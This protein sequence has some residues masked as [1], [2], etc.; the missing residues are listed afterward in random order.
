MEPT[1]VTPEIVDDEDRVVQ[2][3]AELGRTR[4]ELRAARAEIE[5]LRAGRAGATD[6][7][8]VARNVGF[9]LVGAVLLA[10]LV[11]L[12]LALG[13]FALLAH[14]LGRLFGAR[15]LGEVTIRRF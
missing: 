14:L 4:I 9:G 15:D 3:E 8:R 1:S 12:A 2:L 13:A 7:A 6:W 5:R 11:I 10:P